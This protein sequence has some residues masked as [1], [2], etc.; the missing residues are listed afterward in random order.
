MAMTFDHISVMSVCSSSLRAP[1]CICMHSGDGR[2]DGCGWGR[3]DG[4]GDG[5]GGGIPWLI[6]KCLQ[7]HTIPFCVLY[8]WRAVSLAKAFT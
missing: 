6:I 7:S 8:M 3:G 1:V 2:G 4:R 5:C